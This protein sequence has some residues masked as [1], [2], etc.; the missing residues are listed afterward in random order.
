MILFSIGSDYKF[1]PV[2]YLYPTRL[3]SHLI[4]DFYYF[5]TVYLS[6]I[7]RYVFRPYH[8]ENWV[9][10]I[11]VEKRGLLNFPFKAIKSLVETTVLAFSGRLH[12]TLILNP[13]FIFHA[14]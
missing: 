4:T 5:A 14:A 2:I 9:V 3:Q 10:I 6:I 7:Q 11:D 1:R 13:S 12:K 8:I